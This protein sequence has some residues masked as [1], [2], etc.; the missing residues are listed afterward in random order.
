MVTQLST[1]MTNHTAKP[2]VHTPTGQWGGRVRVVTDAFEINAAGSTGVDADGDYFTLCRLPSNARIL[3]FWV[4][5][6]DL[7]SGSNIALNYGVYQTDGTIVDEDCF[8]SGVSHQSAVAPTDIRFEAAATN[9]DSWYKELCEVAG[10][11]A[12]PK[13][14]YDVVATNTA[15]TSGLQ[16]GTLSFMIMYTVD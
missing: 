9:I 14:H 1:I 5:S 10:A 16:A 8:A 7:D 11:S 15:A 4:A 3:Q 13:D 12:D 2:S 6:D